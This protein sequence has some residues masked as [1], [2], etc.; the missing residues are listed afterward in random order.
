VSLH[1][2]SGR[3]AVAAGIAVIVGVGGEPA[4]ALADAAREAGLGR[5]AVRHVPTSEDAA[6][7]VTEIVEPG[8]LVL[9]KGSR[10]VRMER[11]VERV[12]AEFS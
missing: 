10:G 5:E 9:V 7:L 6:A 11:V 2:Q 12:E 4:R 1:A 8:D 3:A